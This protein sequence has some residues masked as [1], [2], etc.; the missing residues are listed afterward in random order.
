[1]NIERIKWRDHHSLEDREWTRLAPII[2][3]AE[4]D[5]I[6]QSYGLILHETDKAVT[7]SGMEQTETPLSLA[8][9]RAVH[10]IMKALIVE[11]EVLKSETVSG[12]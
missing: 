3:G 1:M 11:R 7:I 5:V 2:E 12:E 4:D 6:I 8:R 10:T 9:Y